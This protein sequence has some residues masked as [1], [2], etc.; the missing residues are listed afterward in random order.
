MTQMKK[1]EKML[2]SSRH[3]KTDFFQKSEPHRTGNLE[4]PIKMISPEHLP[5]NL[6]DDKSSSTIS[7]ESSSPVNKDGNKVETMTSS[8]E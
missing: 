8:L 5:A 7:E 3:S 1:H 2:L 6:A 4:L